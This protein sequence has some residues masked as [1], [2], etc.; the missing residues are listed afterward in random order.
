MVRR[1]ENLFSGL[2]YARTAELIVEDNG[3]GEAAVEEELLSISSK[4]GV[5][6]HEDGASR[7]Q[8]PLPDISYGVIKEKGII[9][10][11]KQGEARLMVQDMPTHLCRLT[12]T[13]IRRVGHEDIEK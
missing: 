3:V 6:F 11:H 1:K 10:G 2:D 9:V 7:F 8:A 4:G 13:N 12:F 5:H